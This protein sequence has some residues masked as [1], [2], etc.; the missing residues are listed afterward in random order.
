V[1][2]RFSPGGSRPAS[3]STDGTLQLWDVR[4]W[5]AARMIF[6]GPPTGDRGPHGESFSFSPSGRH[7]ALCNSNG[8]VYIL[9]LPKWIPR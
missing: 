2:I 6:F 3:I 1:A 9:R 8:T 7:F 4:T 5:K